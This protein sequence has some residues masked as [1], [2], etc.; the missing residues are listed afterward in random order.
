MSGKKPEPTGERRR[1]TMSEVA[2]EAGCS[3]AT[4]SLVLSR[5]PGTNI[6][7]RTRQ[8]VEE[9]A[10]RLGYQVRPAIKIPA[11]NRPRKTTPVGQRFSNASSSQ[12]GRVVRELGLAITS[13]YFPADT[14]LPR[15]ADLM[16]RYG[17]SRTVLREAIKILSGKQ[18]LQS[19]A[20]VGTRVR[21]RNEWNLFDP[22]LLMWHAQA[23]LDADFIQHVGE[24]RWA[25]EPEAAALAARRHTEAGIEV[26]YR[27][28]DRMGAPNVSAREF[29]DADLDLHL[30]IAAMAANPFMRAISALIEFALVAALTKSWPGDEA[31]GVAR[32]AARHRDIIAAIAEGDEEG[33]R[34]AMRI[35][36][37]EGIA[38]AA[39]H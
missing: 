20:R 27:H 2:R 15:D 7:A 33:A 34:A 38:R 29:I 5:K 28:A 22:D 12:T 8:R 37:S 31:G 3:Q 17:V 6:T 36:I 25:L 13:G 21:H 18:L 1:A 16:A 24:I 4:V 19:R 39:E 10:R 9:A 26:L 35:V 23:G 30:A 14:I 32:S 11:G